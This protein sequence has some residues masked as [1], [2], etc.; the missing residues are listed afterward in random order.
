MLIDPNKNHL[1][2]TTYNK[3]KTRSVDRGGSGWQMILPGDEQPQSA[4]RSEEF[5]K[6]SDP[7]EPIYRKLESLLTDSLSAEAYTKAVR[8]S[9]AERRVTLMPIPRKDSG[10]NTKTGISRYCETIT[11]R[12]KLWHPDHCENRTASRA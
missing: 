8:V 5:Q 12:Q 4:I 9:P 1:K 11:V 7:N 2:E 10:S 6:T 3:D